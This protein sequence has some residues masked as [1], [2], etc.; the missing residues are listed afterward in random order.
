MSG[1][2]L[3]LID[4]SSYLYR[5][6]HALPPLV[7]SKGLPTGAV[8]GVVKMIR[9]LVADFEP[10][11]VA[12]VFDAKGKTF[13]HDMYDQ[14]K[15]H[16]PPMPDDLRVQIEP[17]HNMIRAMRLPLICVEGVEAD[18][19]IGTLAKHA[20]VAGV[21]TLISTGDKDMAQLVNDHVSLIN[22]MSGEALDAEGVETKYGVSPALIIDYLSLMG[23]ASDNV[24]GVEKVGPKTAV[25]WLKQ[26]GTLDDVMAQHES[27]GG[28]VGENL[29]KALAHLPLSR[30]LVT[31]KCDVELPYKLSELMP[32]EADA[33]TLIEQCRELEFKSWLSDL[34]SGEKAA[35]K[36]V[37]EKQY[38]GILTEH[39]L[40]AWIEK[41]KAAD[42]V[43]FDVETTSLNYMDAEIVGLSFAIKADEAIYIPVAHDY[44]DAPDQLDRLHVLT[45]L[46]PLLEDPSLKKLGHNLK[47]DKEVLANYHIEL[48]GIAFDTMLASYVLDSTANRHDLDTLCLKY[49][50]HE[51]VHY[52]DVAGKGAKQISFSQV[53]LEQAIPYA[54][55]DAD[56]AFQLFSLFEPKLNADEK[57]KFV[58]EKIELPVL[59]VLTSI[60]RHGVLIDVPSLKAQ[61]QTLAVACK[62]LEEKA[63]EL[64]GQPFNLNSPKQLQAILYEKLEIPILKKTPKG[65]PSTAEPVL[66]ELAH[67]YELPSVILSYRSMSKLKSTYTDRLPEVVNEKTGRV[68]TSYHQA[69]AGTGRLSSSDPNLQNIPVRTEAGRNI[70]KAFI[71]PE[72]C[73]LVAADYSQIELRIMAHLSNDPGLLKAFSNNLDVHRATASEVFGV[74]LEDVTNDQRRK[75]KAINFGLIYGMSAFG[76]AKQLGVERGVAQSYIDAY[77]IKYPGVH[78]YMENTRKQAHETG[79]VETLFGRRLYLAEINSKNKQ[80]QL[81]AERAAINAPMQGTAADIIKI[82][83]IAVDHWLVNSDIDAAMIMQVHDELVFEVATPDVDEAKAKITSLMSD[84]AN[85]SVP[86]LV[87]VGTGKN[88]DEAH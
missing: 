88:W 26:F 20:E 61:S 23:D 30:E 52:E 29:Q 16:R 51:N 59:N 84:A 34:L 12:V 8:Y 46:K 70:R 69:V 65:Q 82:A 68:H 57:L 2:K 77:F 19:V 54:A 33:T 75:A 36:V 74:A 47:Y 63:Y 58:F 37:V 41:I 55:E 15:A 39:D 4:G 21:S 49:L 10:E 67:Q 81:G 45:K 28:K 43:A 35:T 85:L 62:T 40:E 5:A 87:D 60:E 18:D 1:E 66:Q 64:S 9:K 80:R 7:N 6:F 17:L 22:T 72:G 13:R 86:L 38:H 83:M 71:A 56:M 11:Y 44:I 24:P 78:D 76:L 73:V 53:S 48:C 79:F 14:Y 32:A 27:I 31:I 25:K 50:G 42:W 3:L